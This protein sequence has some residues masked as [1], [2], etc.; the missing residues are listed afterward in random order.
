MK[1]ED[2]LK[3]IIERFDVTLGNTST[4]KGKLLSTTNRRFQKYIM[5][6]MLDIQ[7]SNQMMLLPDFYFHTSYIVRVEYKLGNQ[8]H[9]YTRN[10]LYVVEILDVEYLSWFEEGILFEM[11]GDE[12]EMIEKYLRGEVE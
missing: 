10:S 6:A 11:T 5:Y 3:E 4:I 7:L 9:I 12:I 1:T 8:F 2:K